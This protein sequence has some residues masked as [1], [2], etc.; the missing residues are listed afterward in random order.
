MG[1]RKG[2]RKRLRKALRGKRVKEGVQG[3][4]G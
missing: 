3:L 2:L 1:L 4:K